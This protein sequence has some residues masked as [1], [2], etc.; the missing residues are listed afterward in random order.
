M[1]RYGIKVS[2]ED[3]TNTI[4]HGLGGYSEDDDVLDLMEVVAMLMIPIFL[5]AAQRD[6][7]MDDGDTKLINLDDE[8]CPAS[9]EES[10]LSGPQLRG[11]GGDDEL[12]PT[13]PGLID[14]V[15]KMILHDVSSMIWRF[16][17]C[18]R[19]RPVTNLSTRL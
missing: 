9:P 11:D 6:R 15:L 10:A 8:F 7:L 17:V 1:S 16:R 14:F 18:R 13:P 5:K 19:M 4:L 12:I 2:N 3:V